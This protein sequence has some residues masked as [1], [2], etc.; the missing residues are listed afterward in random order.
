MSKDGR[1]SDRIKRL[2]QAS[3]ANAVWRD[4]NGVEH[5]QFVVRRGDI[6]W[7]IVSTFNGVESV[8]Q[9]DFKSRATAE[10][11]MQTH[12]APQF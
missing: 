4:T 9:C 1:M 7:N 8:V 10:E 3:Y 6:G 2:P 11:Y 12:T 5:Q